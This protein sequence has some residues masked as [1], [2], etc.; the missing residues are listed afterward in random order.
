MG[1]IDLDNDN[2]HIQKYSK[3]MT[4][5]NANVKLFCSS[6]NGD[7]DGVLA[8]LSQGAR[9]GWVRR[10]RQ[11][12]SPEYQHPLFKAAC[13]GHADICGLL[14][15]YGSNVNETSPDAKKVT[16]LHSAAGCR[17][18]SVVDVLLSWGAEVDSRDCLGHT[19]LHAACSEGHLPCVQVA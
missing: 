18:K 17:Q 3:G 11:G 7:V 12:G 16:V 10:N 2:I 14:L 4:I 9:V 13:L 5:S 15:A 8:A 19:P 6:F 1:G